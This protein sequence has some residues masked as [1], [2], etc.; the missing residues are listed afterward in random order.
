MSDSGFPS[1][2]I[3]NIPEEKAELKIQTNLAH[4]IHV[5][6]NLLKY[7]GNV[8]YNKKWFWFKENDNTYYFTEDTNYTKEFYIKENNCEKRKCSFQEMKD[9]ISQ[10]HEIHRLY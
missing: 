9:F 1:Q 7:D 6:A 3:M 2:E 5:I 4:E 10:L 8:Q